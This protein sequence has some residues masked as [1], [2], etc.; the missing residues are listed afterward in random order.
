V[1]KGKREPM[2][3]DWVNQEYKKWVQ[4][5]EDGDVIAQNADPLYEEL[6][7]AVVDV[8]S[9]PVIK[10]QFAPTTNGTTRH[11][12]VKTGTKILQID[13]LTNERAIEAHWDATSKVRLELKVAE[14]GIVNLSYQDKRLSPEDAAKAITKPFFFS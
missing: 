6:W 11:R 12:I 2:A 10:S 7:Q 1:E 5:Q 8:L 3:P 4:S 9:A 14:N 13:L